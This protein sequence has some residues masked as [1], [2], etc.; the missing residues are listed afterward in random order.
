MEI[1]AEIE[2]RFAAIERQRQML[3]DC[4]CA[5]SDAQLRQA[6]PGGWSSVQTIE[7]L[8]LSDETVGQAQE[9]PA[10]EDVMFRVLPRALRRALVLAALRRDA[11]LPLPSPALEPAGTAPL[12]ALL[13]RWDTARAGMRRA[14]EVFPGGE[15]RWSHPVLGPLTA[16]QMLTLSEV[17]TAYHTRQMERTTGAQA[18]KNLTRSCGKATD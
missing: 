17:H 3:T 4:V 6:K 1:T 5:L 8:V 2:T 7:H 9:T 16:L 15:P 18:E 10:S 14:L 13:E 11:V 12:P